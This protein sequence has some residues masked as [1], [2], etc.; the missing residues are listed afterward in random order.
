MQGG[1]GRYSGA[2]EA[3][4]L[5]ANMG[6]LSSSPFL[7]PPTSKA[8]FPG[9]P[10]PARARALTPI[11]PAANGASTGTGGP[12]RPFPARHTSDKPVTTEDPP[13]PATTR[14]G[15]RGRRRTFPSSS[16]AE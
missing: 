6:S 15:R 4:S 2:M 5:R 11:P 7:G 1:Q 9:P 16:Y 8:Y 3:R 12:Q 13:T 10:S 14:A